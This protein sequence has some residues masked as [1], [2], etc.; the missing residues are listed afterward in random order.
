MLLS[1]AVLCNA[2]PCLCAV[3]YHA[4][5]CWAVLGWDGLGWAGLCCAGLGWA[6]LGWAVLICAG[7]PVI[8]RCLVSQ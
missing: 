2:M 4:E 8:L 1:A 3:M 6:G 7:V 5:L